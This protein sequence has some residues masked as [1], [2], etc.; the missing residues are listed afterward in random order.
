MLISIALADRVLILRNEKL[1][2]QALALEMQTSLV[3]HLKTLWSFKDDFMSIGGTEES[4]EKTFEK[5]L[6]SLQRILG[7]SRAFIS[8][9]DQLGNLHI[10][11]MGQTPDYV[12]PFLT[13][14][15]AMFR[16][17]EIPDDIISILGAV[18]SLDTAALAFTPASEIGRR[19]PEIARATSALCDRL[20]QDDYRVL[21]PLVYKKEIC[22]LIILGRKESGAAYL[23]SEISTLNAFQ[24]TISQT[25]RNCTLY[26]E[27]TRLKGLAEDRVVKLSDYVIDS[28]KFNHHQLGE[29]RIVYSSE[30]MTEVLEKTAR[31]APTGQPILITGETGT[32]KELIAHSVHEQSTRDDAPFV[33]MNC[34]AIPDAL[35]ESEMFG[36]EKGAFTDASSA[37]AGKVEQA[38]TGTLFFDEIGEIPP[39]IQPK[40]LR[41]LQERKFERVGGGR[42]IE[43]RCR[44]VFATNRDLSAMMRE[45]RFRE[46]LYYRINVFQIQ[47]PPLRERRADIPALV[48]YFTKKYAAELGSPVVSVDHRALEAMYRF[49]WPGNIRELENSLIQVIVNC[50]RPSVELSDLPRNILESSPAFAPFIN[51]S[52]GVLEDAGLDFEKMVNDYA[53]QIILETLRKVDGNIAEA[54]RRLG[55]KRTTFYYKRKELGID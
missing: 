18:R 40:L 16:R 2:A 53:R 33:A 26:D 42:L 37:R 24:L 28:Q 27:L 47:V 11:Q 20:F 38:G 51:V 10:H 31:F 4:L 32:G 46:D 49:A 17:F 14:A 55:L 13:R 44:F 45:G 6:K 23:E 7:F 43:A 34:A 15:S 12:R 48:E 21:I 9:S 50:N 35:W 39:A 1:S 54:A 5:M 25:A 8:T 36:H 3:A 19:Y 22:G 29:K 41:L 30:R 52:E